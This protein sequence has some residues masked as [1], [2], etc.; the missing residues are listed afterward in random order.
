MTVSTQASSISDGRDEGEQRPDL[1]VGLA[2]D[3]LARARAERVV[4]GVLV[5][6][7]EEVDRVILGHAEKRRRL[8]HA[9]LADREGALPERVP[10]LVPVHAHDVA[11]RRSSSRTRRPR[12]RRLAVGPTSTSGSA[13]APASSAAA[14][15]RQ[16]AVIGVFGRMWPAS[17]TVSV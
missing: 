14:T 3:V 11:R 13:P 6:V 8:F 16:A 17:A 9:V 15:S 5:G 7:D 1:R 12:R 4:E 2:A 10:A